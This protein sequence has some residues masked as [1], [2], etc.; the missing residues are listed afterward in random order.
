LR[1]SLGALLRTQLELNPIPRSTKEKSDN[2]YSMYKFDE[3][4]EKELTLWMKENLGLA[5]FNFDNTSKEIGHLEENLI[6]L[7]VPPLNLKDNPDNPYSAAIKTA[8]KSCM[9][10]AREYAGLGLDS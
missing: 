4:S 10:A 3:K 8:R 6:Q 1:R 9:E 5:F 7:A 2:K